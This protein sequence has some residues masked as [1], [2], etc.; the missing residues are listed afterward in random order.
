MLAK[1]RQNTIKSYSK[2]MMAFVFFMSCSLLVFFTLIQIKANKDAESRMTNYVER[3]AEHFEAMIDVHFSFLEGIANHLGRQKHLLSDKNMDLIKG[4]YLKSEF[5]DVAIV[6]PDGICHYQSGDENDVGDRQYFIDGM[7][8]AK[9]ISDPIESRV[10]L[11][12]RVIISVPVINNGQVIG[13][14]AA[15]YNLTSLSRMLFADIYEGAGYCVISASD[16]RVIALSIKDKE[17]V[18]LKEMNLFQFYE[19]FSYEGSDKTMKEI[20]DDFMNR[21]EGYVKLRKGNTDVRY[22]TYCPLDVSNWTLCYVVPS[23]IAKEA[24]AFIPRYELMLAV[25]FIGSV[26]AMVCYMMKVNADNERRLVQYAH[27]DALTGL[28]NKQ[29]TEDKVNEWLT[30]VKKHKGVQAFMMMDV[31]KFKDINDHFGHLVGDEVLR[32][33][34]EK[35]RSSFRENDVTGRIGGDEFVVFMENI[36]TRLNAIARVEHLRDSL[37]KMRFNSMEGKGITVSIGVAFAPEH[38]TSYE[39]LYLHADAALYETKRKGRDG[40]T[41]YREGE[42]EELSASDEKE[43]FLGD[44]FP[45][46]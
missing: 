27:T 23:G 42:A 40:I 15:S 3:Q 12:T 28:S 2:A 31:D 5:D 33:I 34:G 11:E 20:Q 30:G 39:S 1:I 19:K 32:A 35:M 38:G 21:R 45:K 36:D 41:V 22:F 14:V 25:A 37:L 18:I 24:Y 13:L 17:H 46:D 4:I 43:A 8:G 16:G 10:D 9:V 6:T 44:K 26:L 29:N 7:K